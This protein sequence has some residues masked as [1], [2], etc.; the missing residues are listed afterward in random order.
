MDLKFYEYADNVSAAWIATRIR[1]V[2]NSRRNLLQ[3]E[4]GYIEGGSQT[5]VDALMRSIAAQGGRVHLATPAERI[6]TADG[7]V[8]GAVVAADGNEIEVR[9]KSVVNATGV[10]SDELRA[11]GRE[12]GIDAD[13]AALAT[14]ER[15]RELVGRDVDAV[16]A[17]VARI[18][19]IKRFTILP[20]DLTRAPGEL[21]P[22]LKIK[23]P[24]VHERYAEQIDALYAG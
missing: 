23:R 1:R 4:L 5:L 11:L 7:K 6:E 2:G 16:N 18:E 12:L 14:N 13:P 19:Q 22:T 8:V 24:V 10:W 9:A 15:V 20:A 3:E 21:T 17:R